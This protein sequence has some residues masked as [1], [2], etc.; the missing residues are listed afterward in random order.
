MN[1]PIKNQVI[2]LLTFVL[3]LTTVTTNVFCQRSMSCIQEPPFVVFFHYCYH[4]GYQ[5]RSS[6]IVSY[7]FEIIEIFSGWNSWILQL[8]SAK[9]AIV[10]HALDWTKQTIWRNYGLKL[11]YRHAPFVSVIENSLVLIWLTYGSHCS[12]YETPT[13]FEWSSFFMYRGSKMTERVS[14]KP[15]LI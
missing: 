4:I 10:S 9:N 14:G 1:C 11:Y 5:T 3:V 15:W 7:I 6:K 12:I 13:V 2:Y 8:K